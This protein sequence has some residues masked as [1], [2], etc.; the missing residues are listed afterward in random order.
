VGHPSFGDAF[1]QLQ[2]ASSDSGQYGFRP[3]SAAPAAL[4]GN[5]TVQGKSLKRVAQ[6]TSPAAVDTI[7]RK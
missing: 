3:D 1:A 5:F 7:A 2:A 4:A 6:T